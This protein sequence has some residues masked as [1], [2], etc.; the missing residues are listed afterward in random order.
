MPD[1]QTTEE[2]QLKRQKLQEAESQLQDAQ[3]K[4]QEALGLL[5]HIQQHLQQ[6]R[7]VLPPHLQDKLQTVLQGRQESAA[8]MPCQGGAAA[9]AVTPQAAAPNADAGALAGFDLRGAPIPGMGGDGDSE[10]GSSEDED[11]QQEPSADE[12]DACSDDNQ[13][14]AAAASNGRASAGNRRHDDRQSRR[15]AESPA[16]AGSRPHSRQQPNHQAR[17]HQ[18]PNCRPPSMPYLPAQTTQHSGARPSHSEVTNTSRQPGDYG[19]M[20][21]AAADGSSEQAWEQQMRPP[22]VS[23][24]HPASHSGH[25]SRTQQSHGPQHSGGHRHQYPGY[26]TDPRSKAAAAGAWVSEHGQHTAGRGR[27]QWVADHRQQSM[28]QASD[29]PRH[30]SDPPQRQPWQRNG[31]HPQGYGS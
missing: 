5:Q 21:Q 24:K 22:Y 23:H 15:P 16:R 14:T 13:P 28:H 31:H 20:Q 10:Y 11:N 18:P 4:L 6:Q 12:D 29:R 27:Q 30:V 1:A 19:R 26:H 7:F 25:S 2:L 9:A 8:Q 17:P 3:H